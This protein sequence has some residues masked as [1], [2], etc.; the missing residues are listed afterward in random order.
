MESYLSGVNAGGGDAVAG[1][2]AAGGTVE[3][4]VGSGAVLASEF[5]AAKF[6]DVQVELVSPISTSID[7][8]A[9]AMAFTLHARIDGKLVRV[10]RG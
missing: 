9:G 7:G 8:S 1:L 10:Q 3:D 4:P 2:F 5:F 6:S